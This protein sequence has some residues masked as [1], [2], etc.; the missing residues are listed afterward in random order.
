MTAPSPTPERPLAVSLGLA[1]AAMA[2][3]ALL[4]AGP[5]GTF[6]QGIWGPHD[7][8]LHRD[9][10]GAAWL[11][12]AEGAGGSE[13]WL[14]QQSWPEGGLPLVFH[15]PNPWDG[16]LL[17]DLT[18][19]EGWNRLQLSHHLANLGAAAL[20]VRSTGAGARG[21]LGA[22]ALLA[23]S[24]LMLHEIAGG[25]T[26]SGVAWPGLLALALLPVEGALAGVGAGLL[27]GLQGLCYL[28]TGLLFGLAALLLRPRAGLLAASVLMAPYAAYLA[29]LW[30]GL[31]TG[32]PPAGF[33]RLPLAGLFTAEAVPERFRLAPG[34]VLGLL[35]GLLPGRGRLLGVALLAGLVA[36]GD[37]PS[38]ALGGGAVASPL[39]WVQWAVPGLG[40][41]HHPVRALFLL[42]PALAALL[43]ALLDRLPRSALLLALAL[44]LCMTGQ[45]ERAAAVAQPVEPPGLASAAWLADKEGA[46]VDLTGEGGEALGL[47]IRHGRPIAEGLRQGRGDLSAR[48]RAWVAGST[49]A[50]VLSELRAAGFTYLLVVERRGP[51]DLSRIEAALGP[52]VGPGIYALATPP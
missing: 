11:F 39:A 45:V 49:D 4:L 3:G 52:P 42:L 40:R 33:T 6:D 38:W 28:Y 50:T 51:V 30:S 8:W 37:R 36:L 5:I 16:W 25:R 47:Q 31:D 19:P 17:H 48:T 13:F 15:I 44:A 43:A 46:I 23:A 22:V 26:L 41:M 10:L 29:P 9:F 32:A 14:R 21:T 34:L 2:L 12:W 24:P 18:F 1:L 20:F 35:G 7:P 27:L